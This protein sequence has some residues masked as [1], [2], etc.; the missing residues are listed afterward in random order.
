MDGVRLSA[1]CC[2]GMAVA[3]AAAGSHCPVAWPVSCSSRCSIRQYCCHVMRLLLAG[4][5]VQCV[6][7]VRLCC[8]CSG[9][10]SYHPPPHSG[11]GW[12]YRGWW[13]GIV[14][15][16]G[17]AME[18]RWCQWLPLP[19]LPSS[20]SDVGV[21]LVV[22]V[23]AALNGGGGVCCDAPSS[24]WGP[25]PC[26]ALLPPCIVLLSFVLSVVGGGVWWCLLSACRYYCAVCF[27]V[28][29]L[30]RHRMV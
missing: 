12:G 19:S 14:V 3:C 15:V 8:S 2:C 13:G 26:A 11:G 28:C 21:P 6:V 30:L 9:V 16:G 18:G 7:R 10:S 25:A 23:V 4:C 24:D 20:L 17:M 5:A 1:V 22:C 29:Y 27:S